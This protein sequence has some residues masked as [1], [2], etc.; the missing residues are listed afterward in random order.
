[1][2]VSSKRCSRCM[3]K[4]AGLLLSWCNI[5]IA[6]WVSLRLM[7][8]GCDERV[9]SS[10]SSIFPTSFPTHSTRWIM[11]SPTPLA[12]NTPQH[13][14][15]LINTHYGLYQSSR[16]QTAGR[17]M[18]WIDE[19][20]SREIFGHGVI[21]LQKWRLVFFIQ[22][23][24]SV[25]TLHFFSYLLWIFLPSAWLVYALLAFS[26]SYSLWTSYRYIYIMN[27]LL[28]SL[29]KNFFSLSSSVLTFAC[30]SSALFLI[31]RRHHSFFLS[32]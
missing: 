6:G 3:T 5:V 21:I 28:R 30:R 24:V 11:Y 20:D 2:N 25:D 22:P 1:M 19:K 31:F 27:T 12:A 29:L 15:F 26:W 23:L 9:M 10:P 17:W 16:N 14:P 32:V 7:G 4:L 13:N 18:E 8:E